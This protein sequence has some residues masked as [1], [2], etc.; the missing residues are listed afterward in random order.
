MAIFSFNEWNLQSE[1]TFLLEKYA[2]KTAFTAHS[3]LFKVVFLHIHG[4]LYC[5]LTIFQCISCETVICKVVEVF[6]K[7]DC[8]EKKIYSNLHCMYLHMKW[9]FRHFATIFIF[10]SLDD[11]LQ[12][13][14]AISNKKM[15]TSLLHNRTHTRTH[16]KHFSE[17]F[18]TFCTCISN[19]SKYSSIARNILAI[20]LEQPISIYSV[21]NYIRTINVRNN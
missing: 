6:L 1:M 17:T 12:I 4:K 8:K 14:S 7:I 13:Y 19:T 10:L 9:H 18:Q 11:S 20:P 3:L 5:L 15:Y 16:I 21:S 2:V